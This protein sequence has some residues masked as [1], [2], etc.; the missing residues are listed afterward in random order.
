MWYTEAWMR[1]VQLG[2]LY[3]DANSTTAKNSNGNDYEKKEGSAVRTH[4][5]ATAQPPTFTHPTP[6][7]NAPRAPQ[8]PRPPHAA[9]FHGP[10][11]LI[12]HPPAHSHAP[13]NSFGRFSAGI[14]FSSV[15]LYPLPRISIFFTVTSSSHGRMIAHTALNAHGALII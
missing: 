2:L 12:E 13:P 6:K 4:Y 11:S 14:C 7:P 3:T 9:L 5:K 15:S 1:A 10:A 8:P